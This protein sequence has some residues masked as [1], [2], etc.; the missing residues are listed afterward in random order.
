[1]ATQT[2]VVKKETKNDPWD[3]VLNI[4]IIVFF[5]FFSFGALA[6]ASDSIASNDLSLARIAE[7]AAATFCMLLAFLMLL[8]YITA[9]QIEQARNELKEEIAQL[10]EE[11]KAAKQ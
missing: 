11:L 8:F 9:S 2:S 1:M 10:R 5:A 7:I 6:L 4:L 3:V